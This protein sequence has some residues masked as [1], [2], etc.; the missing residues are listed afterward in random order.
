MFSWDPLGRSHCVGVARLGFENNGI[1]SVDND[2]RHAFFVLGPQDVLLEPGR[3]FVV[4][5][6]FAHYFRRNLR[7]FGCRKQLRIGPFRHINSRLDQRWRRL[8]EEVNNAAEILRVRIPHLELVWA[9]R[10]RLFAVISHHPP[11]AARGK[12]SCI[13]FDRHGRCGKHAGWDDRPVVLVFV[14]VTVFVGDADTANRVRGIVLDFDEGGAFG[15]AEGE[16]EE[17]EGKKELG[18]S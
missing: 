16:W 18:D 4:E 11:V 14:D 17:T 7:Y 13:V 15:E 2:C 9:H 8:F 5:H 1:I 3:R 12:G 10:R 6:E